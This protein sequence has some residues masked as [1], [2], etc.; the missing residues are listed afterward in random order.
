MDQIHQNGGEALTR[1]CMDS[2][3]LN[4]QS[5]IEKYEMCQPSPGLTFFQS[6]LFC[7]CLR[8]GHIAKR[9]RHDELNYL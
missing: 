8:W 9:K 3:Y 5:I 2:G 1:D 6:E 7:G 4:L